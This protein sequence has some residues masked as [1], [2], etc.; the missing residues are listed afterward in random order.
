MVQPT[1]IVCCAS[2]GPALAPSAAI[3]AANTNS[4]RMK[5]SIA[6]TRSGRMFHGSNN[7][8]S[9]ENGARLPLTWAHP[10]GGATLIANTFRLDDREHDGAL[11]PL[12]GDRPHPELAFATQ[13][14]G[15]VIGQLP[16]GGGSLHFV[17]HGGQHALSIAL[18]GETT[19]QGANHASTFDKPLG[20]FPLSASQACMSRPP[21]SEP[22]AKRGSS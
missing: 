19:G 14:H 5:P 13:D 16:Y 9:A 21:R 22:C 17:T 11:A 3:A 18:Q 8:A 12:L 10:L 6:G 1:R 4:F 2:D 7:G 20:A 15:V